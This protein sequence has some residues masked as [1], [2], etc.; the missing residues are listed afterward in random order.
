[1]DDNSMVGQID[2]LL[3]GGLQT[4][5]QARAYSAEAVAALLA[6]L[7]SLAPSDLQGKL[8]QA[9]FTLAPYVDPEDVDG[10]EQS[11]A[12][13][14]YFER[15]RAWC[16]LPELMLPVRSAWSCVLWRI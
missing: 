12:T 10:I 2:V 14:M 13:C 4:E 9:G 11:C 6:R 1:M 3:K 15:H 8:V 7:Q 16:D 5:W